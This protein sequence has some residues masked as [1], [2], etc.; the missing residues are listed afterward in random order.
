MSHS[1]TAQLP[2]ERRTFL[3]LMGAAGAGLVLAGCGGGSSSGTS[4]NFWLTPNATQA[5]MQA[6]VTRM[7]RGFKRV[8]PKDKVTS[9][10]IPW[11]NALTKYTAAYSGANPPDVTYQITLWLNQWRNTA[12]LADFK[13]LA[14]PEELRSMLAGVPRS[15]VDAATG[16]NGEIFAI[17]FVQSYFSLNVNESIWIKAGKPPLPTTYEQ[18]ITFARATTFDKKGRKLGEAGFDAGNVDHYGMTWDPN[19]ATQT[20]Y[21]WQYFWAYG[22]DYISEDGK[23]IGFNNDAGRAALKVMKDMVDCG[24]ATPP[25]L[26][27]DETKW[28][29]AVVAG[30]AAMGWT[31]PL[32]LAQAQQ[33]P[34]ARLKVIALPSGPHGRAVVGGCGYFAVASKSSNQKQAYAFAK[35]LLSAPQA[36]DYI[37]TI[38]GQPVHP[39]KG[40]YYSKPLGDPRINQF[41]NEAAP[42]G[43]YARI[44]KILKY[45]PETYLLGKIN[46]YLYGRQGMDQM[47]ADASKQVK[48][49]AR[50]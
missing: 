39:V 9:L 14:T 33:Y 1:R 23:D 45:Q 42:M 26:Y 47:I 2:V 36:N 5:E 40:D 11:D 37:R 8:A 15:Y 46:D 19:P 12:A 28:G 31:Q 48:Q 7:T 24:G 21:V 13:K 41:L 18:M 35:Y 43:K 3:Q 49:M 17:P 22:T 50:G 30:E 20:N 6:Y 16:N 25:G 10:I 29:D 4:L 34:K 32:T 38:L 44:G 27:T